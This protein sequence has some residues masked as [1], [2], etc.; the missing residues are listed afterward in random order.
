MMRDGVSKVRNVIGSLLALA[1]AT[2][3][4]WSPFRAWYDGRHGRDY[5]LDE[6]FSRAGVTDAKAQLFASLFLPFLFAAVVT[7]A[8]I[9]LRSRL[10]IALAGV[11]V[12]GFTILWMVRLGQAQGSLTVDGDGRGVDVGA[13]N[14]FVGGAVLLLA[15]LLMAGRRKR[16]RAQASGEPEQYQAPEPEQYQPPEPD[17]APPPPAYDGPPTLD[18]MPSPPASPSAEAQPPAWQRPPQQ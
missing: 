8:G 10:L 5:R 16:V 11:V 14:A 2:A 4:V 3:A 6:L 15:A 1:G 13:A 17:V 9:L 12:L 18:G 7:L